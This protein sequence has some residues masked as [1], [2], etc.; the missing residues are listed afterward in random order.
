[1]TELTTTSYLI[2]GLLTNRERS[3]Y[4]IAEQMGRGVT[5][6]WPRAGRQLYDPP[7]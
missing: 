7:G 5:E 4:E 6:V 3:A 2:L 1:M